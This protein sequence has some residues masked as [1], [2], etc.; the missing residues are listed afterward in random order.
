MTGIVAGPPRESGFIRLTLGHVLEDVGP[1]ILEAAYGCADG[2][3]NVDGV[4]IHDP[5][6]EPVDS[7]H[8]ILLGIGVRGGREIA[9]LVSSR[10]EGAIAAVVVRS[11]V[12]V[13]DEL[14]R[15]ADSRGVAVLGLARGTTWTQLVALLRSVL[16]EGDLGD[17]PVESLGGLPAGD[18][19][20]VANA[21]SSLLDAP[22]TIEDRQ[23]RVLA[24]SARQGEADASRAETILDRQV[25]E[26]YA[27]IL[28]DRGVFR[29]LYRLD[30]PIIVDPILLGDGVRS[31]RIAIAVRAGDEILGSIWA[32]M[33]GPITEARAATLRESASLVALHLLRARASADLQRRRRTDLLGRALEG[34]VGA[35]DALDQLSLSGQKV[36]V[37]AMVLDS[38]PADG[39]WAD[40][41]A[42]A[43][44]E[45]L[46]D[47]LAVHLSTVQP[48]SV[49]A[50][51]GTTVF[52]ILPSPSDDAENR[53]VRILEDFIDRVGTRIP[54]VAAVGPPAS[55]PR[56]IDRS[57]AVALRVLRVLATR[58]THSTAADTR[59][60]VAC[61]DDVQ[62]DALVL[63][64]RDLM[65]TRR[66]ALDG[67]VARLVAHD[68]RTNGHLVETL[69]NWLYQFG[70]VR[71]AAAESFVH[72]NT[73]RYRLRRA[74][75]LG[76]IDLTD[77]DARFAAM[78]HLRLLAI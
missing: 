17:R 27:R 45:R 51:L 58:G 62:T 48:G 36:C 22:V 69:R 20:A 42:A 66:E 39:P 67:P 78:L 77:P 38:P 19:F 56:G 76:Q 30:G 41:E 11:P 73:F 15:V 65:L 60:R 2:T 61:L 23:S 63:E 1:A 8:S 28:I 32:V 31:Q 37:I 75:E 16:A 43:E 50:E 34:G 12:E 72:P 6:D 24:F 9:E 40:R 74:A 18:L 64:L 55:G 33:S 68:E 35:G 21:I 7:E 10:A 49:V 46:T 54:A 3:R 71:A 13:T 4:V 53:A 52:G 47:A 25:P 70:D 57:R 5:T 14:R 29:D 59:M 26:R 44:R